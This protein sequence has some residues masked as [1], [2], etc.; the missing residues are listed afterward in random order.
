MREGSLR[1]H[2]I[3]TA[4][5]LFYKEGVRT[6]TMDKVAQSL[7]MSKRTL[8]ELFTDKEDLLVACVAASYKDFKDK[9]RKASNP[10]DTVIDII[11]RTF[12]YRLKWAKN[13]SPTFFS[14]TSNY[15]KVVAL[16]ENHREDMRADFCEFYHRGVQEG[17]FIDRL[18]PQL[19][20]LSFITMMPAMRAY[21]T[22]DS[23][24]PFDFFLNTYFVH[25]RGFATEKGRQL[26]DEFV[27]NYRREHHL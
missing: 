4:Q 23:L 11:L 21:S 24:Q 10:E 27:V 19:L 18:N 9:M 1:N 25:V 17:L 3:A 5:K 6:V 16:F 8:Y 2:V 15:P 7:R 20:Y 22:K 13:I 12:S 14:E 26:L